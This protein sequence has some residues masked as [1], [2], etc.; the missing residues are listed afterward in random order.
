[1]FSSIRLYV[2]PPVG[3]RAEAKIELY[4]ELREKHNTYLANRFAGSA[5]SFADKLL[6]A[7]EAPE[8]ELDAPVEKSKKYSEL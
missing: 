5:L 8:E 2:K 7:S 3:S 6:K 1:M 4:S